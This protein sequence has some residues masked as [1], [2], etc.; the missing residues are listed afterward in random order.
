MDGLRRRRY[1]VG[2]YVANKYGTAKAY[3][4]RTGMPLKLNSRVSRLTKTQM[5]NVKCTFTDKI[6]IQ[7]GTSAYV[8]FNTVAQF[9]NLTSILSGSAEWTSRQNQYSYY[10]I[11]GMSVTYTRRWIDPISYGVNGT[12]AGFTIGGY[13]NGLPAM[14][15]N[16]YPNIVSTTVGQPTEDADSSWLTSPYIHG[17]QTHYQPFPKN[18][19]TGTN[20]N[21]LGV[22]NACNAVANIL[23]QLSIYSDTTAVA[24]D[25]SD[26]TIFDMEI[27][28]YVSFC[29]NLGT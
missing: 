18:F 22:W 13:G 5:I 1:N 24:S 28:M 14:S 23:G 4:R 17:R 16:F 20:S 10:K 11:N 21:G 29:N 26:I 3:R 25:Q 7:A 15:T 12:S 6:I 9:R 2:K 19:T 8:F 27:N